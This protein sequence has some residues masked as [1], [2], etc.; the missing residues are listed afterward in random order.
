MRQQ[1]DKQDFLSAGPAQSASA[2]AAD[3]D[4]NM[5]SN[6]LRRESIQKLRNRIEAV[7]WVMAALATAY[8]GNGETHILD[9]VIND[10]SVKR[11]CCCPASTHSYQ[12]TG[13][14][15]KITLLDKC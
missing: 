11:F 8:Y 12:N 9:V 14:A 13:A 10:K 5:A 2:V 6:S 3:L 4:G 15:M 1:E 7:L